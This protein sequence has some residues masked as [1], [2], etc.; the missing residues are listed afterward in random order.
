MENNINNIGQGVAPTSRQQSNYSAPLYGPTF[1]DHLA[2]GLSNALEGFAHERLEDLKR[3]K[4][5][6]LLTDTGIKPEAASFLDDI[7]QTDPNLFSQL[8]QNLGPNAYQNQEEGGQ[9]R[10]FGK[11]TPEETQYKKAQIGRTQKLLEDY[12]KRTDASSRLE[13]KAKVAYDYLQKN[14]GKLPNQFRRTFDKKS[15]A[16]YNQYKETLKGYLNDVVADVAALNA[17]GSGFRS[18]KAL[19]DLAATAKAS[20]DQPIE[21]MEALLNNLIHQTEKVK[22]ENGL[23]QGIR[24]NNKGQWPLNTADQFADLLANQSED[25]E[26][27]GDSGD[28]RVSK[29]GV[30]EAW[31]PETN[32][33]EKASW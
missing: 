17:A 8:I 27:G 26:E 3:K 31:N 7:R 25:Q 30:K 6:N 10:L 5:H 29:S 23:L 20:I 13:D 2:G 14:K 24:H 22:K 32:R 11:A 9:S 12:R 4:R 28:V 33:W 1:G 21:T 19:T 18:G 16:N 15:L